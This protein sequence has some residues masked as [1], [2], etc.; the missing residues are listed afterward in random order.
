M[1][2]MSVTEVKNIP[3]SVYNRNQARRYLKS[4][5]IWLT[6][7]DHAFTLDEI[8]CRDTIENNMNLSVDKT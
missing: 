1:D 5:S 4:R 8:K 2:L 3:K 6:K 7:S